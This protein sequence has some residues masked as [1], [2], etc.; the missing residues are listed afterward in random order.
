MHAQLH[1]HAWRCCLFT[2]R[3]ASR[4]SV[5]ARIRQCAGTAHRYGQR[6]DRTGSGGTLSMFRGNGCR[7][8]AKKPS[9]LQAT[10]ASTSSKLEVQTAPQAPSRKTCR[11]PVANPLTSTLF[12]ILRSPSCPAHVMTFGHKQDSVNGKPQKSS[13]T[14]A[15][16]LFTHID[17]CQIFHVHTGGNK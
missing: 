6:S 11:A 13:E 9:C 5:H 12:T 4:L 16:G 7:S 15:N 8:P 2:E 3:C 17:T 1:Q 10:S 14:C